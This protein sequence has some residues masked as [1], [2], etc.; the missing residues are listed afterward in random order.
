MSRNMEHTHITG[1]ITIKV[2]NQIVKF[3]PEP[4]A[5]FLIDNHNMLNMVKS[6]IME[7][8][9]SLANS[10]EGDINSLKN[11]IESLRDLHNI[12]SIYDHAEIF[13][14]K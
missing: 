4:F 11:N 12:I 14:Q 13:E 10:C 7:G 6:S 3:D 2:N 9:L 8:V 5:K 1:Y